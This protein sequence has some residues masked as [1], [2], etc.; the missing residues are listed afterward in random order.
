MFNMSTCSGASSALHS[1]SGKQHH[2]V[3]NTQT[4]SSCPVVLL[5]GH[6]AAGSPVTFDPKSSVLWE[7]NTRLTAASRKHSLF[8]VFSGCK[9]DFVPFQTQKQNS[10][11]TSG[12]SGSSAC[13]HRTRFDL[14]RGSSSDSHKQTLFDTCHHGK[15]PAIHTQTKQHP[16]RRRAINNIFL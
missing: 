5:E 9:L 10:A 6:P 1:L 11:L 15:Y 8:C 3:V 2:L 4:A 16:H 13:G 12:T 14:W 7:I